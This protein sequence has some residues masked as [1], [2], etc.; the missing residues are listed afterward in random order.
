V[1]AARSTKDALEALEAARARGA[2]VDLVLKEHEPPGSSACRL[3]RRLAGSDELRLVPVV[4]GMGEM[5]TEER[6]GESFGRPRFDA[7]VPSSSPAP[8]RAETRQRSHPP[9]KK[10][11]R[12]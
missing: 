6:A 4:G 2:P 7:C 1:S 11:N 8:H 10:T 9:P 12:A 5:I 3:L